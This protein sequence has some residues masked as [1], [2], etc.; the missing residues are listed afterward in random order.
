MFEI[1]KRNATLKFVK[2]TIG[3][4]QRL[5][6]LI[7]FGDSETDHDAIKDVV[8]SNAMLCGPR[9]K[10]VELMS[11]PSLDRLSSELQIIAPTLGALVAHTSDLNCRYEDKQT[12][13]RTNRQTDRPRQRQRLV[14]TW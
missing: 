14:G 12:G 5:T 9:C 3:G 7:S 2:K 6:N 8:W 4:V 11:E 13:R 1:A 10:T